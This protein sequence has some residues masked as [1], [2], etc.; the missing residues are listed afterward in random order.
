MESFRLHPWSYLIFPLPLF[1]QVRRIEDPPPAPRLRNVGFLR[2]SLVRRP[3]EKERIHL[4]HFGLVFA[5]LMP[6]AGFA[7]SPSV[8]LQGPI[9]NFCVNCQTFCFFFLCSVS[10]PA[11][12]S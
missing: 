9:A 12:L 4:L 5:D 11:L 8:R 6:A 10:P 3:G 1:S 2:W 7:R